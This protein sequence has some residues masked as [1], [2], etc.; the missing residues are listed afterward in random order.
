MLLGKEKF[1]SGFLFFRFQDEKTLKKLIMR[2]LND[3][4]KG[5][6]GACGGVVCVK[7]TEYKKLCVK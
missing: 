1:D 2:E 4:L 3:V 7:C 5:W 6:S